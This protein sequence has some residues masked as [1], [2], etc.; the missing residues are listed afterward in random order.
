MSA[1]L[2]ADALD[3]FFAHLVETSNQRILDDSRLVEGSVRRPRLRTKN[4]ADALGEAPNERNRF[5]QGFFARRGGVK[6]S[7]KR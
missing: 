3:D 7:G 5:R 6:K 2:C 4:A 1:I